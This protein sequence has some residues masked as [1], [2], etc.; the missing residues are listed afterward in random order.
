MK[1]ILITGVAGMIGSHLLDT[2]MESEEDISHIYG[3]DDFSVGKEDNIANLISNNRF[4]FIKGN[5][6][7]RKF[8]D[9]IPD[10]D[11]IVHLAAAKKLERKAPE[12][13]TYTSMESELKIF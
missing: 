9:S 1:R 12:W 4:T 13:K 5:I 2:L 11:I 7:D 3:I 8:L 6:L 10:V